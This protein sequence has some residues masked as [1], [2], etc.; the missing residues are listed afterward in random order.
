[1]RKKF[2]EEKKEIELENQE[3]AKPKNFA[4]KLEPL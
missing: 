2:R 4:E 3:K 1:M